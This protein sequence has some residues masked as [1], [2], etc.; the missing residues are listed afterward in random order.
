MIYDCD[1]KNVEHDNQVNDTNDDADY[2]N[3]RNY[4]SNYSTIMTPLN[5]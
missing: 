4:C 1:Q 5:N 3:D 2:Y